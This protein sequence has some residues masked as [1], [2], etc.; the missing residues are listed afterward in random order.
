MV[1]SAFVRL[2]SLPLTPNGKIDRKSL[3]APE[4]L[5][6]G[7]SRPY[8]APQSE[9]E[10]AIA[11]VWKDVLHVE[12]VG[13]HDNF[14]D[15][16]GHSLLIAKIHLRLRDI[17]DREVAVVDLFMHPTIEALAKH[18]SA[19]PGAEASFQTVQDRAQK[20]KDVQERQKQRMKKQRAG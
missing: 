16:G 17:T 4:A 19:E 6:L 1:P 14:F 15:L 5:Q 12:Q 3:P 11:E 9:L 18:I 20:R 2:D 13:I 7:S 10:V 8:V